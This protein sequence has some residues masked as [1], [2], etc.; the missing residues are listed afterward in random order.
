M[1]C[2]CKRAPSFVRFVTRNALGDRNSEG[3]AFFWFTG[4]GGNNSSHRNIDDSMNKAPADIMSVR[5]TR[6]SHLQLKV[7][8]ALAVDAC[9]FRQ[10]RTWV[11]VKVFYKNT[12]YTTETVKDMGKNPI[13]A[14]ISEEANWFPFDFTEQDDIVTLELFN[15]NNDSI[16]I[17]KL[18]FR[19]VSGMSPESTPEERILPV[20]V[21][22]LGWKKEKQSGQ[23]VVLTQ[24]KRSEASGEY[25]DLIL[26]LRKGYLKGATSRISKV[27]DIQAYLTYRHVTFKSDKLHKT[28]DKFVWLEGSGGTFNFLINKTD[29]N[30]K[31]KIQ[32]FNHRLLAGECDILLESLKKVEA[33]TLPLLLKDKPVGSIEVTTFLKAGC[34]M[35]RKHRT[36]AQCTSQKTYT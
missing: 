23:L 1:R 27:S 17:A 2:C 33:I 15:R 28:G 12:L 24:M 30:D 35:E 5:Q 34:W 36:S 22:V 31:I 14:T 11:H 21:P 3:H 16:G 19:D 20:M 13:W 26:T 4:S 6:T 9:T 29:P 25:G 8:R 7:M 10:V 18:K 32:V